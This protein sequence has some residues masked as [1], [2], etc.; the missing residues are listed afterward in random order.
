MINDCV[1]FQ[2]VE[3][4]MRCYITYNGKKRILSSN[5]VKPNVVNLSF[6]SLFFNAFF[7][8]SP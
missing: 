3:D 2:I 4:K 7:I 6:F 1:N 5:Y 8:I